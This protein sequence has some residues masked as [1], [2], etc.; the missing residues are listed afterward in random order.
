LYTEDDQGRGVTR[1][2]PAIY[3]DAELTALAVVRAAVAESFTGGS[4]GPAVLEAMR[5]YLEKYG[6]Y[7]DGDVTAMIALTAALGRLAGTAWLVAA[8]R[9]LGRFPSRDEMLA[10][11]DSFELGMLEQHQD[12]DDP[13]RQQD[14]DGGGEQSP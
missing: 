14:A 4:C 7:Q 13:I 8:E 3:D 12:P 11:L 6:T 1:P 5:S 2:G 9:R 10:E